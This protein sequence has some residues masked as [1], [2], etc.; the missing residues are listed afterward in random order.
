MN[1]RVENLKEKRNQKGLEFNALSL[2]P[3]FDKISEN[4]AGVV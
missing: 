4:I 1:R 3:T 2:K